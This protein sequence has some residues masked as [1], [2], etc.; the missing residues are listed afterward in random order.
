[1]DEMRD[2]PYPFADGNPILGFWQ[3]SCHQQSRDCLVTVVGV[4]V[5]VVVVYRIGYIPSLS[6]L[7]NND[8]CTHACMLSLSSA[9]TPCREQPV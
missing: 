4:V 7:S 8:A 3:E 5:V 2:Q 6:L 9:F 1:M